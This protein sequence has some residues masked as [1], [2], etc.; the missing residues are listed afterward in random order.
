MSRTGTNV[1]NGLSKCSCWSSESWYL[2][3]DVN[4]AAYIFLLLL[5]Y[6]EN[7]IDIILITFYWKCS[8]LF[9]LHLFSLS[10]FPQRYFKK[11]YYHI[12]NAEQWDYI[13]R[14]LDYVINALI[15]HE[16]SSWAVPADSAACSLVNTD[17]Y[18]HKLRWQII[19]ISLLPKKNLLMTPNRPCLAADL[20]PFATSV[21]RPTICTTLCLSLKVRSWLAVNKFPHFSFFFFLFSIHPHSFSC[22]LINTECATGQ[23]QNAWQYLITWT[24]NYHQQHARETHW[25]IVTMIIMYS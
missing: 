23:T 9:A 6:Y 10:V 7:Y 4:T 14:V 1:T 16:D 13:A 15:R 21:S 22:S 5:F 11:L 3:P 19:L 8:L 18:V 12:I 25:K 20:Q 2:F 17:S 24:I